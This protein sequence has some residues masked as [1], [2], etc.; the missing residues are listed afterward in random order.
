M[1]GFRQK[2]L[3]AD[4]G[5]FRSFAMKGANDVEQMLFDVLGGV[6]VD[7]G[8]AAQRQEAAFLDEL[9]QQGGQ[10]LGRHLAAQGDLPFVRGERVGGLDAVF[11]EVLGLGDGLRPLGDLLENVRDG[12][13]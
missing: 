6:Q 7:V 12:C 5:T 8:L 11:D 4:A 3:A 2:L 13:V 10:L 9:S 1:G